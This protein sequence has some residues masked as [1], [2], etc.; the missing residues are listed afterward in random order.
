MSY[1]FIRTFGTSYTE[2]GGFH[3]WINKRVKIL[4][5][6][7]RP[8]VDNSMFEFSWP[9]ILQQ[10]VKSKVINHALSGHGNDRIFREVYR[11]VESDDFKTSENSRNNS[12]IPNIN[13][14]KTRPPAPENSRKF[15]KIENFWKF[16]TN[17]RTFKEILEN[18]RNF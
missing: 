12:N 13:I 16:Q 15:L 2:G 1:K 11:I 5:N 3:Y 17:W 10:K 9:Y 6:G 8:M 7:L 18:Y 14:K 4:Y